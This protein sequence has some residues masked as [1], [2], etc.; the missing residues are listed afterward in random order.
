MS[1][2]MQTRKLKNLIIRP[3]V[4]RFFIAKAEKNKG[5]RETRV[6]LEFI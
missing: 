5:G 4:I 3:Y 2:R 6:K 1:I